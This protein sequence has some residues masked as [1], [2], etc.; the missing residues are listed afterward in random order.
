MS[1]FLALLALFAGALL[2]PA[3]VRLPRAIRGP[4]LAAIP[5][6]VFLLLFNQV[7]AVQAGEFVVFDQPWLPALDAHMRLRLDGLGLLMGLLVSGI[8][9]LIFLYGAGYL[10]NHPERARLYIA[11]FL[12]AGAMFGLVVADNLIALFVFWE[13][14]SISSY[15]LIG[16]DHDAVKARKNALQALL[17]TGLGGLALLAGLLMIGTVAETYTISE[18]PARSEAILAHPWTPAAIVLI[19]L[20]AFTKSAQVPF[21]FWLVNAMVAPTPISAYLHSATMVKAG[22]FLLARLHPALGESELWSLSLMIFGGATLL[23]GAVLGLLQYDLKRILAYTTLAVLGLLTLLIGIGSERAIES[24]LL[25]LLGHAL[26]KAAL[27]MTAGAID[28]ETG[29]RDVRILSGLRHAMPITALA[30]GLAALSKSGFPPFF[31]FI[32]KEYVYK[33][34]IDLGAWSGLILGV[35]IVGNMLLLALAFKAGVRPFWGGKQFAELPKPHV[36]EAPWTMWLPPLVLALVGLAIGLFPQLLAQPLVVTAAS[37]ILAQDIEVKLALWQ[38]FNVPLLLSLLTFAGGATIF[39][40]RE[41]LRPALRI[42]LGPLPSSEQGYG[43]IMDQMLALAGWQTRVLQSGYLRYYL[44]ITLGTAGVLIAW[45]LVRFGSFPTTWSLEVADIPLGLVLLAM[46][47]GAIFAA[48]ARS[49]LTTLVSLGIVGFGIA[50]IFA[51]FG[52]PDLAITQILVETLTVLL[53]VF[54]VYQLPTFPAYSPGRNHVIDALFAGALGVLVSAL[55]LVSLE[56]Q[57]AET[58]SAQ[59]SAWSYELAKGRN[60]VNVILVD[61]RALDT[62]GEII[63]LAIAALGVFALIAQSRGRERPADPAEAATTPPGVQSSLLQIASRFLAPVLGILSLII[64]YRGHNLPGGGFIG[65]LVAA[66]A[67]LLL[68]LA[69]GLDEAR[70]RLRFDPHYLLGVGLAIAAGSGVF[71]L[72]TGEP[73][74]TG[75]WLPAFELP[76]LGTVHLGTPLLFDVGVYLTVVGFTLT[77]TFALA[78]PAA[79]ARGGPPREPEA[80]PRGTDRSP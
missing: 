1:L 46:G 43:W 53:F 38:G 37:S 54:V 5:A 80:G 48:V 17:V 52:A 4:A 21:H 27:F 33:A 31:G 13:L 32:G 18:L 70:R 14:T 15:L 9:A 74:L 68:L 40:L 2:A 59:L 25:F 10:G 77:A 34:G 23:T 7:G 39:L 35:A 50:L 16:F 69:S 56:V 65:G 78:E 76:G 63:V 6:G 60:I 44:M 42:T 57:I 71:G 12:F 30:A 73:F 41:R 8:G 20:G 36:H 45:Q 61:F 66:S 28:H 62:L 64:L 75:L 51:W 3:L 26:Y 72:A 58:V 47:L 79:R 49:R 22:V 24:A 19:L 11:F 67:V 55:V 29:T